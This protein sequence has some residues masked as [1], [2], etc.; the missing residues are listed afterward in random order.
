MLEFVGVVCYPRNGRGGS[1]LG[2]E[3]LYNEKLN[4]NEG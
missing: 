4:E 3:G 2:R 1:C